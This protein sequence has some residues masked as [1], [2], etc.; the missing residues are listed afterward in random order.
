VVAE[1]QDLRRHSRES[2]ETTLEPRRCSER[3]ADGFSPEERRALRRVRSVPVL[4]Q[5]EELRLNLGS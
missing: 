1:P 5:I 4:A 3:G 2:F